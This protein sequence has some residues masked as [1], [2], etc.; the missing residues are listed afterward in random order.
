MSFAPRLRKLASETA[1]YGISSVVGRLINFALVPLYTNVL[2]VDHYGVVIL[3]YTAF[4]FLNIV[5]TYGMESAYLRYASGSEGRGHAPKTFSTAVLSIL[6]TSALL[7]VLIL[8]FRGPVSW[9][10]GIQ[11]NWYHLLIFAVLILSADALVVVPMAELRL[12]NR[13]WRFAGI[14]LANVGLNVGLNLYL[15]LGRGMGVEAIFIAN[16]AASACTVLL[17]LPQYI[18]LLRPTFS[19][20]LWRRLVRFGLPFVPGGI[21]YVL[22]ERISLFFLG[23]LDRE[24]VI[25]MYGD[26][27]DLAGLEAR[28]AEAAERAATAMGVDAHTSDP[29]VAAQLADAIDIT[30]G[31]HVVSIFGTAYKLAIFM[32]LVSQMFRF[33]W[34]P[35]FLQHADDEDA[36]ALFSRVFTLFTA[37]GAFVVVAVSFFARELVG[38]PIGGGRTLIPEEY[39]LG[40]TVVPPVL[41][42]YLFQGWYYNFSAGIYIEKKTKYFI[43]CTV[44]GAVV[45]TLVTWLLVPRLGMAGAAIAVLVAFVAM[46][47]MLLVYARRWYPI[48]YNWRAIVAVAALAG[49]VFG[50]WNRVPY[51]QVWWIE[52]VL[53]V[54]LALGLF[55]VGRGRAAH[56]EVT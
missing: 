9:L 23:K 12:Q 41:L 20:V 39:W 47:L 10:I 18:A 49:A 33:A 3:V 44:V 31:Q 2:P 48:A 7:S 42:A 56:V 4:I 54:I 5:Y 21:A 24:S 15:I 50:V 32:M 28:A 6:L 34:Q 46:A 38:I 53:L 37:A 11:Q 43:H 16:L 35:F 14:R 45:S 27:I 26:E 13:P 52:M 1:V 36:K 22:S 30:F 19:P 8:V 25:A 40:L 51:M 55:A 29:V 17:L